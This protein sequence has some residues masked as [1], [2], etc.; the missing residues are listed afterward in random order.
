MRK[1]NV[2]AGKSLTVTE[3]IDN[4][5]FA[6]KLFEIEKSQ[7]PILIIWFQ[8]LPLD[9]QPMLCRVTN[10][11]RKQSTNDSSHLVLEFT[12]WIFVFWLHGT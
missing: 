7:Q 6:L 4:L 11:N 1:R 10:G 3:T 5:R 8:N 12:S 9:Q 2:R